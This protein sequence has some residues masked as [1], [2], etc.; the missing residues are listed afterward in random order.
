MNELISYCL[1]IGSRMHLHGERVDYMIYKAK[2]LRETQGVATPR[3]LSIHL[4]G[5][6]M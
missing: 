2:K 1:R 4:D 3:P 5:W 6:G